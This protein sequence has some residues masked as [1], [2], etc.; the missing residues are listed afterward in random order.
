VL[1]TTITTIGGVLPLTLGGSSL[2]GPLGWVI[3]G[4]LLAATLLTLVVVPVL[5]TLLTVKPA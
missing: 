3:I 4:G 5:Y 2:W 1:L